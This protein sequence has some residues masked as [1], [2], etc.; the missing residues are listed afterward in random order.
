MSH[1]CSL[2]GRCRVYYGTWDGRQRVFVED[3]VDAFTLPGDRPAHRAGRS[4]A[5]P[6]CP[7]AVQGFSRLPVEKLS[8]ARTL[9]PRGTS[10][11]VTQEPI[12]PAAPG[13]ESTTIAIS[14]E[15]SVF[16]VPR[17]RSVSLAGWVRFM[18]ATEARGP[19]PGGFLPLSASSLGCR[20]SN[21]A[22]S[23]SYFPF[24]V[25]SRP[26]PDTASEIGLV[27]CLLMGNRPC[28]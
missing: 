6:S 1:R 22:L 21:Q 12:K 9:S 18:K 14:C 13:T 10:A 27:G 5:R 25:L 3:D 15:H 7:A 24:H 16:L 11:R 20:V 2:C 17:R 28:G 19:H 23:N 8:S 26:T 4:P